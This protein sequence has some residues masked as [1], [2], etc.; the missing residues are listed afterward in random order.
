MTSTSLPLATIGSTRSFSAPT[1]L[2]RH[3]TR[4]PSARTPMTGSRRRSSGPVSATTTARLSLGRYSQEGSV[5]PRAI[6]PSFRATTA[7]TC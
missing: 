6:F 5:S 2:A 1:S 4:S 7:R 3:G